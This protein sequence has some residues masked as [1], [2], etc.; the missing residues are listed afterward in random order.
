MRRHVSANV[1]TESGREVFYCGDVE[2]SYILQEGVI[3]FIDPNDLIK[4]FY[5]KKE[6]EDSSKEAP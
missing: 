5:G 6:K 4:K 3:V 2:V 1:L